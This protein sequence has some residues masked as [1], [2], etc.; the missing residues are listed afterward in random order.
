MAGL[1]KELQKAVKEVDAFDASVASL[2]KDECAKAPLLESEPQTKL[3]QREINKQDGIYL[4]PDKRINSKETFNEKFR[5]ECDFK[6]E[7]VPFIAENKEIIG[8]TIEMWTKPFAGLS[9]EFW[10]VPT[11]KKV[12]GPRYL[13]EQISR[14][15]YTRLTMEDRPVSSEGGVTY[16]GQ[17][18]ATNKISRLDARSARGSVAMASDF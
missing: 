6:S 14:K 11:N 15:N 9:A 18:V 12:W 4:K 13:A 1:S 3:S 10:K 7:Y 17:M 5:K 8:E 2:T 16:T